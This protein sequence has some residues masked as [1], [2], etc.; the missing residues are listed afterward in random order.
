VEK[1]KVQEQEQEQEH[2]TGKDQDQ[3]AEEE[4]NKAEVASADGTEPA[5]VPAVRGDR[6]ATGGV[7]KVSMLWD[8]SL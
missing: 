6:S 1:E 2:T 4:E 8:N 3:P 7:R 5:R